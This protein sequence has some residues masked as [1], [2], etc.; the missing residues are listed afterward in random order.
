MGT[1]LGVKRKAMKIVDAKTVPLITWSMY[2]LK[3]FKTYIK[4]KSILSTIKHQALRNQPY[5]QVVTNSI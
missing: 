1:K 5:A 3:P 2:N 4:V